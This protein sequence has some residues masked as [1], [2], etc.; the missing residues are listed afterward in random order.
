M[1]VRYNIFILMGFIYLFPSPGFSQ[2][3]SVLDFSE[4]V[5]TGTRT[6]TRKS[7]SPVQ[8]TVVSGQTLTRLKACN[9]YDGLKFQTGLRVETNCQTC[10][11]SQLRINGLP[12]GYSQ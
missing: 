3:D 12:G 9:L 8:V 2:T 10:N 11:Y 6:E 7:E 4:L 5:L 1:P